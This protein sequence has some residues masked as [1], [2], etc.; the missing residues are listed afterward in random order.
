MLKKIFSSIVLVFA[1][2]ILV[3]CGKSDDD[4]A[5]KPQ[6]TEVNSSQSSGEGS[7]EQALDK[8]DIIDAMKEN[9][10]VMSPQEV[11]AAIKRARDNAEAAA[12]QTGQ[13][14]EQIKQ[15]GDAAEVVAKRAFAA[16]QPKE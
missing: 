7:N 10:G 6:N 4:N 16:E 14:A 1:L 12:K 5:T 13:T 11:L 2:I 9:S 8:P 3:T 15:A